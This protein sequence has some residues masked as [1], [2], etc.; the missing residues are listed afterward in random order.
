MVSLRW[1]GDVECSVVWHEEGAEEK[2]EPLESFC[3]I[4][5][6]SYTARNVESFNTQP[7]NYDIC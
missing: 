3:R 1:E 6:Y 7:D 5:V 4:V 2:K